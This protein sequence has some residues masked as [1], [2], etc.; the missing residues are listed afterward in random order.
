[1]TT[2]APPSRARFLPRT[3]RRAERGAFTLIEVLVVM[4]ILAILATLTI[5]RL[6][7]TPGR[8]AEV[9]ARAVKALL[10]QAAQQDAVTPGA[11]ALHYDPQKQELSLQALAKDKDGKRDWRTTPMVRPVRFTS[12]LIADAAADGRPQPAEQ[13]LH[14]VFSGARPR[15]ALSL[16]LRTTPDL[17]GPARA[18][19]VDLLPNQTVATFRAVGGAAPIAPA[20][21]G[22][23][24]L[25]LTGQRNQSW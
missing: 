23:I 8:Q 1:M 20:E 25:D 12:L 4:V 13:G 16:L 24:D 18:W 22:S 7:G 6:I 21:G 17:P 5:P 2:I 15:P 11:L 19:Q 3:P 9:E 10:S 14:M